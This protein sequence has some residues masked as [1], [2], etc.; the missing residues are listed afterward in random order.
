M[1]MSDWIGTYSTTEAIK[2]GLDLEMPCVSDTISMIAHFDVRSSGPSVVRGAAVTR[3]L[4]GEKLLPGDIDARVR[5]VVHI[6][7]SQHFRL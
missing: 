7:F 2:A 5:K 1:T 6:V 3:A 4:A